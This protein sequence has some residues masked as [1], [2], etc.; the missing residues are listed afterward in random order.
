MT[1]VFIQGVTYAEVEI[2]GFKQVLY[3]YVVPMLEHPI[4][5]GKPWM[6]H[7]EAY[8]VPHLNIVRH[9]KATKDVPTLGNETVGPF[10]NE[11][12]SASLVSGSLFM[13]PVKRLSKQMENTRS[14]LCKL[15][16]QD[17][18]KAALNYQTAL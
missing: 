5:L 4:I 9:G 6:I 17:I 10:I 3:F 13:A 8:P 2:S 16:I 18:D 15:S 11:L 7:N 1:G 12:K 14:F